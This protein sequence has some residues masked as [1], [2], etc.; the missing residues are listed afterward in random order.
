MPVQQITDPQVEETEVDKPAPIEDR[1]DGD[2]PL[3]RLRVRQ[4]AAELGPDRLAQTRVQQFE[5]R[6]RARIGD[7]HPAPIL[8]GL[9]AQLSDLQPQPRALGGPRLVGENLVA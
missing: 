3:K 8:R 2:E 6:R 9:A 5:P 4:P 1:L 7:A